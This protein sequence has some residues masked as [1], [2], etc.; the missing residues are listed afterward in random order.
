MYS[1]GDTFLQIRFILS[2]TG[3]AKQVLFFKHS[4]GVLDGGIDVSY[5]HNAPW[6]NN[7]IA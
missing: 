1:T 5:A 4:T 3:H 2:G 6:Q 7:V